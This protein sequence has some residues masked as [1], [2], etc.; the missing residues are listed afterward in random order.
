VIA[1][2]GLA[3]LVGIGIAVGELAD[4]GRAG[5]WAIGAAE[6]M[7]VLLALLLRDQRRAGRRAA[8]SA[9]RLRRY[10]EAQAQRI[11]EVRRNQ[12]A[13]G[14]DLQTVQ[15]AAVEMKAYVGST[16]LADGPPATAKP[17]PR[18]PAQLTAIH[19]T[20]ALVN[21]FA[22]VPVKRPIPLMGGWA[23]SPDVMLLLLDELLK[24]RPKL[25]VECGSGVSTLWFALA[26]EHYGLDTKVVALE[27]DER[28][29]ATTRAALVA[30]GVSEHAQIRHAPLVPTGLEGHE[31]PWYD[32]TA[33]GDLTGI[34]LVFVDGPPEATGI[35]PRYPAVPLLGDRFA[36]TVTVVLDDLIRESEQRVAAAWRKLLPDFTFERVR[37]DKD[38]AV[39]RRVAR[40]K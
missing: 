2:I 18:D 32:V 39:F 26:I 7:F 20:Q 29:A 12:R 9:R 33:I 19:Q 30:H 16:V 25:V 4:V 6:A 27:H 1:L 5:Y 36:P 8:E 37:L 11:Q 21:L 31:A 14:R 28:F 15:A 22:L 24:V 17:A 40:E 10:G 35:Q 3:V 34:G 23:A 38:A 13:L